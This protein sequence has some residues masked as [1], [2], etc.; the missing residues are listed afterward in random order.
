MSF[1]GFFFKLDG[2]I[3]QTVGIIQIGAGEFAAALFGKV[4]SILDCLYSLCEILFV[5]LAFHC[6]DCGIFALF[7]SAIKPLLF[8]LFLI[9]YTPFY[10]K[11]KMIFPYQNKRAGISCPYFRY[12]LR[13]VRI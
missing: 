4:Q 11:S 9:H 12:F 5:I 8:T 7:F 10:L 1:G 2:N 13:N 6:L 3:K